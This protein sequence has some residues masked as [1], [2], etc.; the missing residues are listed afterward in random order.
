MHNSINQL[1][2]HSR[3]KRG[4]SRGVKSANSSTIT[5]RPGSAG[6]QHYR[7]DR[8]ARFPGLRKSRLS[9]PS[10]HTARAAFTG[11]ATR[12]S[13]YF[14]AERSLCLPVC[15][16]RRGHAAVCDVGIL[17]ASSRRSFVLNRP[18]VSKSS[19][20]RRPPHP[21]RLSLTRNLTPW[22]LSLCSGV[23][24][25][26]FSPGCAIPRDRC[27]AK[28]PSPRKEGM[29]ID[30]SRRRRTVRYRGRNGA[31]SASKAKHHADHRLLPPG[32]PFR[33]RGPSRNPDAQSQ[34]QVRAAARP[35]REAA[36]LP[37]PFR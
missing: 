12:V 1:S 2:T 15:G 9:Y 31:A 17:E 7:A 6:A 14:L 24:Q 22:P 25:Q 8:A 3:K 28:F 37:H 13:T 18:V 35:Q 30:A 29:L 10:G 33:S 19:F 36:G 34:D 5:C 27:A 16:N 32:R 23:V 21:C 26:E 4:S 20:R 11:A